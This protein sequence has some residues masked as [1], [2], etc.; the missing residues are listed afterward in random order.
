V[1][2]A[3]A[4]VVATS[5]GALLLCS[6]RPV[7]GFW[8]AL[9]EGGLVGVGVLLGGHQWFARRRDTVLALS[10]FAVSLLLFEACVRLFLDVQPRFSVS[11]DP[12]FLLANAL[13]VN[14]TT[15]GWDTGSNEVVCSA[16]YG[17]AYER[18]LNRASDAA[19]TLPQRF[20]PRADKRRRVL[21]VGD[22]MVY[23]LGVP[24]SEALHHAAGA[25]RAGYRAHQR[26]AAGHGAGL[27]LRRR[28]RLGAATD[29][30]RRDVPLRGQ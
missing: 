14:A 25:T 21:H 1:L 11:D 6:W 9:V 10:S 17:P 16:I 5:L 12:S 18:K 7:L 8:D 29:R 4:I 19:L 2:A 24:P 20:A 30:P 15:Q 27:V 3:A 26:G 28:P 13:L 23:G 22:S